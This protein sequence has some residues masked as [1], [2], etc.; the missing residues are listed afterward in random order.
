MSFDSDYSQW[1]EELSSDP[2][3]PA[4]HFI[5][6][7]GWM[8]DPNGTVFWKG[9]WHLFYQYS[10]GTFTTGYAMAH[11]AHAVSDDLVHWSDLP[12]ALAPTPGTY[13]EKG[14]WSGTSLVEEDRVIANYHAHQGGNCIATCSD[15]M[16]VNWEKHPAN[17]VIPFDPAMTYDPCIFKHNGVYY[18]LSGRITG[19][20]HGDGRDQEFGGKDIAYLY[21]SLD[22]SNW[23]YIGPLYEGGIFT[24]PGEDCACPDFFPIGNKY[25]L[26]FLSHNTGAQ[27]YIGTFE[28]ERFTPE[29]HGRMNFTKPLPLL[30][31]MG[32]AGDFSA[33][34]SWAGPDGRR[35]MIA[36]ITEGRSM[37][38][39]K[40]AQWAGILSLPRD[41][42]LDADGLQKI[43][44]ASELETLR[45]AHWSLTDINLEPDDAITLN[46]ISGNT[47]ELL[48]KI[49]PS[50]TGQVGFKVCQSPDGSE[51]TVITVDIEAGTLTI[52]PSHSSLRADVT[53][54]GAQVA[55]FVLESDELLELRIF[56]DRSVVEVFAN[57]RQCVTKRVY[58]SRADS[59][60]VQLFTNGAGAEIKSI[61][62][63]Q[64]EAIWPI[65]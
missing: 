28:N 25:M 34:I 12:I 36:W 40:E 35:I 60:G 22:L 45:G 46:G 62:A 64:M 38:A 51:E 13:D 48:A 14:C 39:M 52:D 56:I 19:A 5:A 42:S 6:P 11:W 30:W 9:R 7:Y 59:L 21:K 33:P 24:E 16:L 2:Y 3:R 44:P 47:I 65:R 20:Q 55:P 31:G 54:K 61:D 41:L 29:I 1:R 15:E 32:T 10:P 50:A 58:P 53:G 57:D 18:S 26:L 49:T 8:N 37:E 27:Y 17:P 43:K 63:W 4:Y 23:E